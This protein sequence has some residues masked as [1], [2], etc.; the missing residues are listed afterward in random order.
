MEDRK[1]Q[2]GDYWVIE[3]WCE[4]QYFVLVEHVTTPGLHITS[5]RAPAGW[6]VSPVA[7]TRIIDTLL[8]PLVG[9]DSEGVP[10]GQVF[11]LV[12]EIAG[13]I[14]RQLATV[15][16]KLGQAQTEAL[17]ARQ[18]STAETTQG[19]LE[20]E[21]LVR[22]AFKLCGEMLPSHV[23]ISWTGIAD[24]YVGELR[25]VVD[26][27]TPRPATIDELVKLILRVGVSWK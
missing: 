27:M 8:A 10:V 12:T 11:G 14:I 6:K 21:A 20:R 18:R 19:Q 1:T 7:R 17:V 23:K 25:N 26:G 15:Q 3:R 4:D 16:S 13:E 24:D 2:F 5:Y 22:G 9:S